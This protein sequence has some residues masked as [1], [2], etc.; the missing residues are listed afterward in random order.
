M[1]K[2]S[3][4]DIEDFYKSI[5]GLA[6]GKYSFILRQYDKNNN[7]LLETSYIE[8]SIDKP[9]YPDPIPVTVI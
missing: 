1:I 5:G 2:K 7:L 9:T 3:K 6:Y 8:F 4:V